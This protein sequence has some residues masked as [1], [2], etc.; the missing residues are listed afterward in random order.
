MNCADPSIYKK[1]KAV[2]LL[3]CIFFMMVN[4]CPVRSLLASAFNPPIESTTGNQRAG[5]SESVGF[6]DVH[7]SEGKVTQAS[8]LRF[9][10]SSESSLPF[11]LLLTVVSLYLS[12]SILSLNFTLFSSERERFLT[13]DIPLFLKNRSIII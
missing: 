11:P 12:I 13:E 5:N 9:S 7:C 4:T 1:A 6:A 10:N 3:L 8:L 2:V